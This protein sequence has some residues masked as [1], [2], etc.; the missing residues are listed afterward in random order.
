MTHLSPRLQTYRSPYYLSGSIMLRISIYS[1]QL[2]RAQPAPSLLVPN[3]FYSFPLNTL[4]RR[5]LRFFGTCVFGSRGSRRLFV[6]SPKSALLS[7][8]R[9][10]GPSQISQSSL[11]SLKAQS[12]SKSPTLSRATICSSVFSAKRSSKSLAICFT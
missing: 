9:I 4:F 1:K 3:I 5:L 11:R 8:P 10:H 2:S 12:T 7:R 6:R